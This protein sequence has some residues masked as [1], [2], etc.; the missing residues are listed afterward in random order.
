MESPI[1]SAAQMRESE[2]AAF[3]RGVEVEALNIVDG[4][5]IGGMLGE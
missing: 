3:G 4:V 1:L 5:L 2:D